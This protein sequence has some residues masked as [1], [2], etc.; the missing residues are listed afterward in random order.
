MDKASSAASHV[1]DDAKQVLQK[2]QHLSFSY[3]IK[4]IDAII[5]MSA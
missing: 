4:D 3:E 2:Y 1:A 5:L